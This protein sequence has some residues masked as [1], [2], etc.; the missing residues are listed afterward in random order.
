M[1]IPGSPVINHLALFIEPDLIL[2]Q[3]MGRL[4]QRQL[5]DGFFQKATALHLRH[6]R[7]A[8]EA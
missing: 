3:L 5:Y 1:Q 7:L 6:E 4:S 2:H 8:H